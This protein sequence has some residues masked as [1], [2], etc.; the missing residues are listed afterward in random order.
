VVRGALDASQGALT[1]RGAL[2]VRDAAGRGSTLGDSV[3]VRYAPCMIGR[4]LAAVAFPRPA[5]YALWNSP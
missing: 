1:V 3:D 5:R 4:A 2:I